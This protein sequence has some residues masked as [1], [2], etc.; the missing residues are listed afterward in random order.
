[1]RGASERRAER[2]A[3][4]WIIALLALGGCSATRFDQ[5]PC[6][7]HAQC[8]AAFG[9]ASVC[10]D[11][12]FCDAALLSA[13]C[14]ASYPEDL[15]TRPARYHEAVVLGTL[16]DRSSPAHLVRERAARLAVK[17]VDEAGGLDGRPVG[18]VMCNIAEESRLD[19]RTRTQA[20]VASAQLLGDTLGTAA[21]IGPS[22]SADTLQV[23][24]AMRSQGTVVI[25]P[26]ATGTNLT[27]LEPT[28]S[29]DR[30]G[31]LWRTAPPDS[32]QGRVIADD[33]LAR[34]IKRVS[35]VREPGAYGEGLTAVFTARFAGAGGSGQV[36]P[37]ATDGQIGTAAADAVANG[38]EEVLFISSQQE[39][40]VRFLNAVGGLGTYARA[41]IFLTDAAASVS[42]FDGAPA[43]APLYPRL[44]GTRPAPR[45]LD[46]YVY[47]AFL[48][49]YKAEYGGEDP[50]VAAFSA[51]AYDATWL[52]VYGA[53]WSLLREGAV[54]GLGIARGLRHVSSGPTTNLVLGSWPAV[55]SAFRAGRS[56]NVSGAS[57]ELDFD[58][59]TREATAP[60]EIWTVRSTAGQTTITRADTG[61][62]APVETHDP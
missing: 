61:R 12:G 30:P 32:L 50:A 53:A 10:N 58:P 54:T 52:A 43:A 42:V 11:D 9:F 35:V 41:G 57:G 31:L 38:A 29:D 40:I 22:S 20:A 59:V 7:D 33:M 60:I 28:S 34:G 13:R 3:D 2:W 39:W 49:N 21:I 46:D 55:V 5:T 15:F 18:L 56:I 26:S 24:Q 4:H 27:D 16:M 48:A 45:G 8:R 25:S 6:E 51:H 36:L 44:R 17:Q 37:I 47:A 14:N 62:P 19:V 23:W 1:L